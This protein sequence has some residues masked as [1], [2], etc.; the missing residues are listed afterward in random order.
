MV[1]IIINN[2]IRIFIIFSLIDNEKKPPSGTPI[3][4]PNEKGII[5]VHLTLN[6][7]KISLL[8]FDPN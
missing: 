8:R 6:L 1:L 4:H 2:A 3:I 7:K 5:I